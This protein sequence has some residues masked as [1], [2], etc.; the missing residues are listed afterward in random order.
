AAD[1]RQHDAAARAGEDR[2]GERY[3]AY[4]ERQDRRVGRAQR[5]TWRAGEES[6]S[7]RQSR[8]PGAIP[9]TRRIEG[10]MRPRSGDELPGRGDRALAGAMA[11]IPLAQWLAARLRALRAR[12]GAALQR[13]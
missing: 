12:A 7:A 8:S 11:N 5:C 6:R 4:Q 3:P 9:G 1:S 10:L 2:P 13:R